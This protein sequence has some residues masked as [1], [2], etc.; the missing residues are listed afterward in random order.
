MQRGNQTC[1]YICDFINMN[2]VL[3]MIPR[4]RLFILA[5]IAL[6]LVLAENHVQCR[7]RGFFISGGGY[8]PKGLPLPGQ[9]PRVHFA[10]GYGTGLGSYTGIGEVQ[11]D[12]ANFHANGDIT[13]QFGSPI[14]Y[15]FVANGDVLAC[16]YGNTDF[17]AKMPGTFELIPVPQLGEGVFIAQFIAQFVP[18]LPECTGKF[19]GV[20]GSWTM[21]AWTAPFVLDRPNRSSTGGRVRERSRSTMEARPVLSGAWAGA[22]RLN[23]PNSLVSI[24]FRSRSIARKWRTLAAF[25]LIASTA[26]ISA[27][28]SSSR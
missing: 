7:P 13:G 6:A 20:G 27:N 14:A 16:Y 11:T 1:S 18:Y 28:E 26:A 24:T 9:Q 4:Q 21:F 10:T 25:S 22:H 5:V 23:P 17:G 15:R 2:E 12:T 3:K 19:S 8:A